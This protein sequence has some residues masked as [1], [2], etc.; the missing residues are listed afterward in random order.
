[1]L[2]GRG[3]ELAIVTAVLSAAG[4]GERAALVIRGEAGVGK[5][6]LVAAAVQ[7]VMAERDDATL[8]STTAVPT[9]SGLSFGGLLG[10]LRPVLDG[11][12][13]LPERQA[14]ALR[15]SFALGP[16]TDPD[17]FAVAAAT[18]GL[19][20]VVAQRG[21]VIVFVDDWQWLDPGSA[22]AL[23]FAAR[24]L[25]DD[26]VAFVATERRGDAPAVPLDGLPVLDLA[27]LD[28][29]GATEMAAGSGLD[30]DSGVLAELVERT[31]GN[32]LALRESIAQIGPL[33]RRGLHPLPEHLPVLSLIHI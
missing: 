33:A 30:I 1:M 2:C 5:T 28:L 13:S 4:A 23:A 11:L 24:R 20:A 25:A 21:P 18:L 14:A 15:S 32:P 8:L 31:S 12:D 16:A 10:V 7:E 27:G 6:A 17:R 3:A 26:Q 29:A 19:L 9:E 22:Q